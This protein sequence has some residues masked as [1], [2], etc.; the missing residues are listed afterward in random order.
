MGAMTLMRLVTRRTDLA[1]RVRGL[2]L[3]SA[4][5]G[6][7]STRTGTSPGQCLVAFGRD[8]LTAT[9]TH[10]PGLVDAARR[11]LPN[12]SRWALR[13][14]ATPAAGTDPLPCRQ[15]LHAMATADIAELWH[16]LTHQRHSPGPLQQ[17]GDRVHLMAAGLD[18]HIPAEQ[19][20]RLAGIL[21]S[22]RLEIV[23][24]AAHSLPVRHARLITDRITR[25]AA[26]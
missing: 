4:P 16:G 5:Y 18:T 13:R 14:P 25:L 20:R 24:H 10:A 7:I 21:P 12:T 19:T 11:L 1:P 3:L 6:G 17:L 2:L 9:C 22:A 23:P 26:G 15:G 8:V